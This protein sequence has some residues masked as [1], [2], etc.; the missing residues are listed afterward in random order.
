VIARS[1]F[2]QAGSGW[3]LCHNQTELDQA[4]RGGAHYAAKVF[5][6]THEFRVHCAGGR[7]LGVQDKN[8]IPH[9]VTRN[10]TDR[11]KWCLIKRED[12]HLGTVVDSLRVTRLL[13]LDFAAVDVM[14]N[15]DTGEHMV[16]ETN[17]APA[18][19]GQLITNRYAIYIINQQRERVNR[20]T[21]EIRVPSKA[22]E[23][24]VE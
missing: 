10:F 3:W 12:A 21:Q 9:S 23:L 17:T 7:V 14:F 5:D 11:A 4:V 15:E 6:H 8:I 18:L 20:F 2:H 24:W 1:E 16:L 19:E 22:A 13:G